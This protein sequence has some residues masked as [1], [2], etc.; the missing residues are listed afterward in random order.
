MA[1]RDEQSERA[2]ARA[3]ELGIP[4]TE[5]ERRAAQKRLVVR[6]PP[7]HQWRRAW[8]EVVDAHDRATR[9]G[10]SEDMLARERAAALGIP[11]GEEERAVMR[12][13]LEVSPTYVA[14]RP[15]QA[16]SVSAVAARFD[17]DVGVRAAVDFARA[18]Q[19]DPR[20][21]ADDLADEYDVDV[22]D[23]YDAYYDTD[24][25]EAA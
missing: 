11:Y 21:W 14:G 4:F 25:A 18:N 7:L 2:R 10:I 1:R 19:I 3:A 9:A 16:L 15:P 24:P 12:A 17:G 5:R 22:H 13:R 8:V 20:E 23:L 6:P